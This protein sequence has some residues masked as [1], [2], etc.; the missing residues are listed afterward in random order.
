M[1]GYRHPPLFTHEYG[2]ASRL[3]PHSDARRRLSRRLMLADLPSETLC[4][5]G[6]VASARRESSRP[7]RHTCLGR[8]LAEV[9]LQQHREQ[10]GRVLSRPSTLP[11]ELELAKPR[12]LVRSMD[13]PWVVFSG[14]ANHLLKS[15]SSSPFRHGS[16]EIAISD[17]DLRHEIA[18]SPFRHGRHGRCS[19]RLSWPCNCTACEIS[20]HHTNII[21]SPRV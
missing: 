8:A 11:A 18:S 21:G 2:Y 14:D 7:S 16:H 9:G 4:G 12:R 15:L 6:H 13:V 20:W 1:I 17:G 19:C 5:L 10:P 3:D